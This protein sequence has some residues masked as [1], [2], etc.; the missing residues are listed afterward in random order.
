MTMSVVANCCA[1]GALTFLLG[2]CGDVPTFTATAARIYVTSMTF[3][4]PIEA[5]GYTLS[6]DGATG[7][8]LGPNGVV[9]FSELE[10]G[11]H[12]LTLA[13]LDTGC[14]LKGVNP[15]TVQTVAGQTAQS[16]FL[17]TCSVPGTARIVIQTFTY[18]V[19][20]DHYQV[21]LDVGR[22]QPVGANDEVT[23][24]AVRAGPVTI[25][26][27]GGA[28]EG[29]DLSGLNPRTLVLTA[30]LEYFSQFKIHCGG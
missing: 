21:S 9:V 12:T 1:W 18:G 26:L 4:D 17:V 8:N 3:G 23:F 24:P 19:G 7:R 13:G 10:A 29:C 28:Q 15:R 30:G 20:P 6:L 14:A 16:Q 27:T 5:D 25:T 11:P 2:A 22:S